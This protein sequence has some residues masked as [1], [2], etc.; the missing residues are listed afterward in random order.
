MTTD[1]E[2]LQGW[3]HPSY[4]EQKKLY[5]EKVEHAINV[6]LF[7]EDK[8]SRPATST[9]GNEFI[10]QRLRDSFFFDEGWDFCAAERLVYGDTL[11]R[12]P[13][14]IGN[15]VG[16]SHCL[17]LATRIAHEILVE[18]DPEAKLGSHQ[19]SP[20]PFIPYSYGAGRCLSGNMCGGGDGSYCSVQLRASQEHGF[21]PSDTAGLPTPVP[22]GTSSTGRS[23]GSNRGRVLQKWRDQALAYDLEH[24]YQIESVEDLWE[25]LTE[26]FHPVQICSNWGFKASHQVKIDGNESFTLYQRG[27]RWAHS[28][29]IL[30]GFR[31]KGDE[32]YKIGNQWGPNAHKDGWYFIVSADTMEAWLRAADA[33]TIGE[34]KGR[35]VSV[36][37]F[38]ML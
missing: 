27:G 11:P 21:L 28:M 2:G 17:L 15:C 36:P 38:P 33:R 4:S 14:N 24:S 18:G 9:A 1:K 5:V 6:R 34:I 20:V 31:H 30:A 22:Q 32:Y 19:D 12:G 25:A 23:W 7:G 10:I 8:F 35:P 29:Q 37:A 3:G 16:Y 26:D 13:Q